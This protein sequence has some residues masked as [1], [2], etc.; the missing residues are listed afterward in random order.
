[1]RE[2]KKCAIV[3]GGVFVVGKL[4]VLAVYHPILPPPS[5]LFSFRV[6]QLP[7]LPSR[8]TGREEG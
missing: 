4:L 1:M 6:V 2:G 7:L 3:G 5:F 8:D